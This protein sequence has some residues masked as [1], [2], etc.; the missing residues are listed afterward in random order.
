MRLPQQDQP[1]PGEGFHP[2]L[3]L[4]SNNDD[5]INTHSA[6]NTCLNQNPH[7]TDEETETQKRV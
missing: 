3:W 1:L 4:L 6:C 7:F 2:G 5:D